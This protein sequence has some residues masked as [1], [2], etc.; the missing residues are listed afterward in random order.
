MRKFDT[1]N[2]DLSID[3]V[4]FST[5]YNENVE[6]KNKITKLIS[7]MR[8][9]SNIL[10]CRKNIHRFDI[11]K[12]RLHSEIKNWSSA[13]RN[14]RW[15]NMTYIY[16]NLDNYYFTEYNDPL[17]H[18][19]DNVLNNSFSLR[20]DSRVGNMVVISLYNMLVLDFDVKDFFDDI[21]P[22]TKKS[23]LEIIKNTIKNVNKMAK[24][25]DLVLV[26]HIAESDQG[27]HLFLVNHYC[28]VRD[29]FWQEFMLCFCNDMLY[30]I[31]THFHGWCIRLSKKEGRKSDFIA[32]SGSILDTIK[33]PNKST[34][35]DSLFIYNDKDDLKTII[36]E[37][38]NIIKFKYSLIKYFSPFT[39]THFEYITKFYK[40][41]DLLNLIRKHIKHIWNNI[42]DTHFDTDNLSSFIT[43]FDI[44]NLDSY[45][46]ELK[47]QLLDDGRFDYNKKIEIISDTPN[48]N[49]IL[50][51]GK[52]S[53]NKYVLKKMHTNK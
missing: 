15:R 46:D 22:D 52:G 21:N 1:K 40:R 48:M 33:L 19:F 16:P 5:H 6:V 36:P 50:E 18:S 8:T 47:Q 13:D 20:I 49:D 41:V 4:T 42:I 31:F 25:L 17:H 11:N 26:W 45:H 38:I 7:L 51:G 28:D 2:M 24:S 23:T 14:I 32:Q 9:N 3:P 37:F 53:K 27:F 43:D 12:E 35:L 10:L 29:L 39:L 34:S 44:K 30:T